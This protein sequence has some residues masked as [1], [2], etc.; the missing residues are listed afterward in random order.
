ML[1]RDI[2]I[3]QPIGLFLRLIENVLSFAR[4]S[5]LSAGGFG[6]ALELAGHDL[7]DARGI[8]AK[9]LQYGS[10]DALFLGQKRGQKVQRRDFAVV[11]LL[12]YL[13][14]TCNSFL[15]LDCELIESHVLIPYVIWLTLAILRRNWDR[16]F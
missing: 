13:L 16:V 2:F 4:Q 10:D 15:G 8:C 1:S 5:K 11:A 12:G 3:F 9:L 7:G 14:G 6:Q